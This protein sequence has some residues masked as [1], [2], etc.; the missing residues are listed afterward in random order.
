MI[1]SA[2]RLADLGSDFLA[3]FVAL[4]KD[5]LEV[6]G[7]YITPFFPLNSRSPYLVAHRELGAHFFSL[8][9]EIIG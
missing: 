2:Y 1:T 3:L 8:A 4:R 6:E 7:S 5:S 9:V